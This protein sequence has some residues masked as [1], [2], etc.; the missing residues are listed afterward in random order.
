[1]NEL[2]ALEDIARLLEP[3]AD[4]RNYLLDHIVEY[5]HQYF[6]AIA[7]APTYRTEPNNAEALL[8]SPITEA[9]IAI[10]EV[11]RLLNQ[12]VDTLGVNLTSGRHLGYVPGG[13]LFHAALGDY[14]AAITNRYAGLF[15][16]SPGAVRLENMLLRWMA[17]E[18]GYPDTSGGNLTSGGSLATLTAI[19][20]ARDA[21]HLSEEWAGRAVIYLTEHVHHCVDK[22]LHVAGL[23]QVCKRYVRV[24]AN[25]RMDA[26]A[27]E[28]AIVADQKAGLK[29]WLVV[30]SAGT[31]NSGAVDPL[32]AIGEIAAI[33]GLWF[34]VDGAYG[35]LFALCPAG[36]AIL[37]GIHQADSLVL[38]P[39]KALFVPYGTGA[40]LVRDRQK[41][42]A[43]FNTEADYIQNILDD[44]DELSPADVSL[45]LTKHFRGL[46]LWLPLKVL[47][48]APFRAALAEKLKLAQYFYEQ[49]KVMDGFEVGPAPDLSIVVYRYRPK[50][51][52]A[53]DFNQR[54]MRAIQQEGRIFI[55]STRI[56]GTLMLRA[57]ILSHRT[58][59]AEI[60]EALD[61][62][63]RQARHL[64]HG[65]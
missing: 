52:D 5:T 29:P 57:A 47:G 18:I 49:V 50:R 22:A 39:H 13:G 2:K 30:A 16:V 40:V 63:Q 7:H 35:G 48:V 38:D 61:V 26:N 65:E 62:L 54:L 31:T 46:R 21:C 34:H 4:A 11:L 17:D 27:L 9:G 20:A 36:K 28:R 51:G 41:L 23:D 37:R 25:Y 53:D 59:L 32:A 14:L 15:F 12:H 10:E 43:A 58:H 19:V 55:S 42:Y 56:G 64:E 3:D 45:E 33:Y 8:N 60:E 6:D 1:M 44:V 24:E